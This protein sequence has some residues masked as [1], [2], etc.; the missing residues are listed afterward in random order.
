MHKYFE[1]I[2]LTIPCSFI[3][4]RDNS[5]FDLRLGIPKRAPEVYKFGFKYL[6][7]RPGAEEL[8][9]KEKVAE[10]VR[11]IKQAQRAQDVE[12]LALAKPKSTEVQ[13][14]AAERLTKLSK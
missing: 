1:I 9:A 5:H 7:L 14:A 2:N 12:I 4:G 13:K 11:L 8:F 10:V 6:G 3:L